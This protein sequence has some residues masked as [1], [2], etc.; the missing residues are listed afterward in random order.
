MSLALGLLLALTFSLSGIRMSNQAGKLFL[1]ACGVDGSLV[2]GV[3]EPGVSAVSWRVFDQ[4]FVVV[5]RGPG[6]DLHLNDPRVS[7]RHAYLQVIAGRLF[8]IDLQ[9]RTGT[10]WNGE[11]GSWGWIATRSVI[12]VGP[13]RLFPRQEGAGGLMRPTDDHA[14]LPVPI[15]RAFEQAN[16]P[17]VSL[18]ILGG[19]VPPTTWRISRSLVLCGASSVCKL[20]LQGRGLSA[21]HASLLQSPAGLFLVDLLGKEGTFVNGARVRSA[22]LVDGDVVAMGE[23]QV[24]VQFHSVA[25]TSPVTLALEHRD[26]ERKSGLPARMETVGT[27]Q[28]TMIAGLD[29][30]T[31]ATVRAMMNEFGQMHGQAT[32]RFQESM[33]TVLQSF[34]AMHGEQM[35]LIRAEMDQIRQ[36]S[37]EQTALQ[38]KMES[39]SLGSSLPP[40]IRLVQGDSRTAAGPPATRN[41]TVISPWSGSRTRPDLTLKE[42][43]RPIVTRPVGPPEPGTRD[44]P[45]LHGQIIHRIATIQ[46][47]RQGRWQKLLK[48]LLD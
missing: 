8:I 19:D 48:T 1:E 39:G 5:G 46:E 15:S 12:T 41:P 28:T 45:D 21:I 11:P 42:S 37:E 40:T 30:N 23:C 44:S 38:R 3:E 13:F 43:S 18:E 7:R 47:E 34:I 20:R 35:N 31:V 4:P 27:P 32:D 17:E 26:P 6:V 2:L 24:R 9:S 33:M 22:Q 36:L 10:C 16:R 29:F 25:T 14:N